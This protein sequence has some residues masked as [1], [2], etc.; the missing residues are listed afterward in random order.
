MNTVR[1][2]AV[3]LCLLLST[4]YPLPSTAGLFDTEIST[5]L[6]QLVGIW[7]SEGYG[8]VMEIQAGFPKQFQRYQV[9]DVSCLLVDSGPLDLLQQNIRQVLRNTDSTRFTF[10]YPASIENYAYFRLSALPEHCSGGGTTPDTDPLLNFD[11]FWST[12]NEQYA[13]FEQRGVDWNALRDQWRGQLNGASSDAD[14]FKVLTELIT[15]LCDGHVQLMSD[16]GEFNGE[17]NPACWNGLAQHLMDEF[18]N[19]AQYDHPFE[20]F[21]QEF[22][23]SAL[24]TIEAGYIQGGLTSALLDKILWGDL[25]G[26]VG[27]L[28]VLQM[29]EYTG[30]DATAA[31]DLESLAPVL[32]TVME[33]FADKQALVIDIRLNTGGYDLVALNIADRFVHQTRVALTKKARWNDGFTVRQPYVSSPA[34]DSPFNR[35]IVIL[36]SDLT[37][38]A[39][40]NFL[41]AMHSLPHVTIIGETTV[42]VHSDVL[43]RSL[44]NGWHFTLSNEVYETADGTVYEGHGITPDIEV[45]S[46]RVEDMSAGRDFGI[47]AAL[48]R[49]ATHQIN[50]GHNDAWYNP[51]TDGQGFYIVVLPE[52][53]KVSLAWFTYDTVLP[54]EDTLSYL[55]D[56]GHRWLTALGKF[57]GNQ[58][59]MR[60]IM[61]S[62]GI[63]DTPTQ[64]QRTDPKGSDGYLTLTFDDCSSGTIEYNITSIGQSGIIPIQRISNDNIALCQALQ[65]E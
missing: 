61:T 3:S 29:T 36:T 16:T 48:T 57:E 63:F 5:S 44:P 8:H 17:M 6:D 47:E 65:Y 43:L 42:G 31:E 11:V 64:V 39:A 1:R 37:A 38:S 60:V 46:P 53:G 58:A 21:Q 41:L 34:G 20:Y 26:G 32:D 40:E 55:G 30:P 45:T 9:N 56:P 14:L 62:G 35:P 22:V 54:P 49:L 52:V 18:A 7:S 19:K 4:S 25:G 2:L 33:S 12:M 59:V 27:Y 23:P 24:N 28:N 51:V 50:P 13:F 10:R 15:P